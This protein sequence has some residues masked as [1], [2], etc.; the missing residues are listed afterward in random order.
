MSSETERFVDWLE[1]MIGDIDEIASFTCEHDPVHALEDRRTRL[2][3][4]RLLARLSEAISRFRRAEVPLAEL[5]PDVP[6]RRIH[7]FGNLI[8]HGYDA[9]EDD[10]VTDIVRTH[11]Q[12]LRAAALRLKAR[13]EA[14][15]S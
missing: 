2:A 1:L 5:E 13:F 11:L 15:A 7:D 6:W 8:R 9:V 4:E 3:V 12:P 14:E 10:Q